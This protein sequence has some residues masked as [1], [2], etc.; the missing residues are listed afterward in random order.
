MPA[1]GPSATTLET[2]RTGSCPPV[3][4][5]AAQRGQHPRALQ[6]AEP[7]AVVPDLHRTPVAPVRDVGAG[8][9]CRVAR[10]R[11]RQQRRLAG[12]GAAAT[13]AVGAGATVDDVLLDVQGEVGAPLP[14]QAYFDITCL[15]RV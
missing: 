11:H 10:R 14:A 3:P 8:G 2:P 6:P 5:R 13:P 7:V 1:R 12:E 15:M 4:R 9:L